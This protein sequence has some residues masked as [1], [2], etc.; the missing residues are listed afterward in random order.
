MNGIP[1]REHEH[2][3]LT[4]GVETIAFRIV[5]CDLYSYPSDPKCRRHLSGANEIRGQGVTLL[6]DIRGNVVR[7][8]QS[9][10]AADARP[11]VERGCTEPDR[12]LVILHAAYAP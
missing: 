6:I 10:A 11:L 8:M 12:A 1:R 3:H 9:A 5:R 2:S 4:I 7:R